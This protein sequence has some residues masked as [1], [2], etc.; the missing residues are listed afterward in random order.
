M[1][2]E[3]LTRQSIVKFFIRNKRKNI[4]FPLKTYFW[5]DWTMTDFQQEPL[6]NNILSCILYANDK[7][8]YDQNGN[9]SEENIL[10][11]LKHF[12]LNV[13]IAEDKY[14][15]NVSSNMWNKPNDIEKS[16]E[17][18]KIHTKKF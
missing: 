7:L 10:K 16:F 17:Y 6:I 14:V 12:F 15:L 18:I 4:V 3:N 11:I 8:Q 13:E 1:I 9:I 2:I 5:D